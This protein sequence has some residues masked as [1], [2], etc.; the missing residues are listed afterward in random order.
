VLC[1]RHPD[2][3]NVILELS[4]RGIKAQP[5]GVL[6]AEGAAGDLAAMLTLADAPAASAPRVA[7]AL[8]RGRR[9]SGTNVTSRVDAARGAGETAANGVGLSFRARK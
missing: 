6:T 1:R 8:G 2:V 4:K 5:S 9:A 7:F 3:R